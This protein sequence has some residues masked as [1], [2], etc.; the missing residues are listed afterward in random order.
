MRTK[1]GCHLRLAEHQGL[2]AAALQVGELVADTRCL[3]GEDAQL[4]SELNA[5]SIVSMYVMASMLY[6]AI[7]ISYHYI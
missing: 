1:G 7:D 6:T 3:V 2:T 4:S 5:S